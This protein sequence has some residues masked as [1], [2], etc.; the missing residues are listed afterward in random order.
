MTSQKKFLTP[1]VI[2]AIALV[3]AAFH[4]YT[5]VFGVFTSVVQRGVHITL[6]II[7]V[8]LMTPFIKNFD[9]P[10]TRIA[11]WLFILLALGSQ[12]Y[13]L[14]NAT[15]AKMAAR[16]IAGPSGYD[17][18]MGGIVILL[19]LEA[20]RRVCMPLAIVAVAF[21]LYGHFGNFMPELIAHRGY[22]VKS[23]I[24]YM[25]FSTEGIYGLPL[26]V[27]ATIIALFII[28]GAFL[29]ASGGG[30]FFVNLA[31][32]IA[33]KRKSGPAL[34]AVIASSLMGTISGS[35]VA[36]VTT[37][38]TFTIPLMKRVGYKPHFSGAVEA[39][40]S[41]GGQIMPPIMGAGAFIMAEVL[42][43]PYLTVALAATIPALLFYLSVGWM[44]HLEAEKSGLK[45]LPKDQLPK[46]MV[47]FKAGYHFLLPLL[48]LVTMMLVFGSTPTS[49][50][51]WAI[52]AV[53]LT[54]YRGKD[55]AMGPK[56]ILSALEIGAKGLVEVAIACAAAGLVIGIFTLSGLGLKLS[57]LVISLSGGN[58]L[59]ALVL[60][61]IVC[62]ILGM[63]VP[64]AAAYIITAALVAPALVNMG[65]EPIAAHLF[66]F[67]FAILS[68]ITP[69]VAL[70]AFAGAGIAGANS[71][72]TGFTATR[73]A[74][75]AYIVPY[76]IVY[77]PSLVL[78]GSP[79]DII[80]SLATALIG[81]ILLGTGVQGWMFMKL[82]LWTR[83]VL[84]VM[85]LALINPGFLSDSIGFVG[86]SLLAI[87]LYRK[88]KKIASSQQEYTTVPVQAQDV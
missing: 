32:A 23:I 40:A 29:E 44:V 1:K 62:I 4:I 79:R 70:A 10:I 73:L 6:A 36:N 72:R 14:F 52:V 45:A 38:G 59:L 76:M 41:T 31:Y 86:G 28:F 26:G 53:I 35:A 25:V 75:V 80:H 69:P 58:L 18:L 57:N 21:L 12:I 19:V 54:S 85:S 7:I 55:S 61:M 15:P 8:F 5:A 13:L 63:G 68:A 65:V 56:K 46:L 27:S 48:V 11:N 43:I 9:N 33:G 78:V 24:D 83:V 50:A 34:S 42:G 39:V 47:T 2:T 67:Y 81:V 3:L 64:T 88:S 82:N 71:M 60:T 17:L 84:I 22:S 49:A 66:I 87:W 37:T 20:A 51:L 74:I 77:G 16:A 30:Q